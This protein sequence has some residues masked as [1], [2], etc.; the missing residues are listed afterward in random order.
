MIER[1]ERDGIVI[2]RLAHGKASALDLEF[3]CALGAALD[4]V[5]EP[6][7]ITGTGTIFSAGVDLVRLTSGGV[8]YIREFLPAMDVAF[9][10]LVTFPRPIVAAVNGHAIAGGCIIAAA[11][12]RR[13]MSAGRIGVP[14]LAVGVPFPALPLEVMRW[15]LTPSAFQEAIV[16][17]KTYEAADA[18]RLGL[19]DEVVA[20]ERLLDA[21]VA[22]AKQMGSVP[23][24]TFELVKRQLRQP[25]ID[26]VD[27]A[28]GYDAEVRR[29]WETPAI[30]D[31]V[32]VYVAKTLKK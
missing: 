27:R 23:A 20:P 16:M 14:E 28:A 25:L 22:A 17:A 15:R 19:A 7:V 21:A 24:A 4:G 32:R 30:L 11:C 6:V 5:A 9:R 1:E 2:L 26:A 18:L 31:A 13:L 10:R 29:L 12:D 3:C 8:D